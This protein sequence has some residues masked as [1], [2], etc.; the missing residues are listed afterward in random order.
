V[1]SSFEPGQAGHPLGALRR[2]WLRGGRWLLP[3]LATLLVS[4]S[5]ASAVTSALT[6]AWV[7]MAAHS[8]SS[9]TPAIAERPAA[10]AVGDGDDARPVDQACISRVVAYSASRSD[11][12][13][14]C[15][16]LAGAGH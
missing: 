11:A 8:A 1:I 3:W 12:I 15:S 16:T 10:S 5:L 13:R 4:A 7:P 6:G 9:P 14:H 2:G